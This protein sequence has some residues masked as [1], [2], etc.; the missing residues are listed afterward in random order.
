MHITADSLLWSSV[1]IL[2]MEKDLIGQE[3]K[4]ELLIC[5]H[6]FKNQHL[7][8]YISCFPAAHPNVFSMHHCQFTLRRQI[9]LSGAAIHHT[10]SK[11]ID[12][13]G[14]THTVVRVVTEVQEQ[15]EDATVRLLVFL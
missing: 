8:E 12:T 6:I 15:R 14:L 13:L 11:L 4:T 7:C 9:L 1:F 3:S 10:D 2:Q 5:I